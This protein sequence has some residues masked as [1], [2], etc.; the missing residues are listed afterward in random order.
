MQA[1]SDQIDDGIEVTNLDD[2]DDDAERMRKIEAIAKARAAV[3]KR[4]GLSVKMF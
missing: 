4:I 2:L 3:P 1:S